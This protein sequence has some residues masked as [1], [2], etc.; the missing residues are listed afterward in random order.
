[1]RRFSYSIPFLAVGICLYFVYVLARDAV[2][3]FSS[4]IYGLENAAFARAVYDLGGLADLGPDGI[5]RL[6]AFLGAIKCAAAIVLALHIADRVR[7][8]FGHEINHELLDA[9][10]MLAVISTFLSAAPALL[11]ATPQFLNEH[12]PALWLA[13]LAATLSMIERVS[14][15]P[16]KPAVPAPV[17]RRTAARIAAY[18]APRRNVSSQR[19]DYLRRLAGAR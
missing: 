11:E 8:T 5:V 16:E 3:I 6:A 13:G 4:S 7:G 18:G 17:R 19:W 12:R 9:G 2:L 1:M 10:V 15:E 14:Q